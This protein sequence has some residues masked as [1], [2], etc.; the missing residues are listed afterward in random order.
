MEIKINVHIIL[1][2]RNS[3]FKYYKRMPESIYL[4]QTELNQLTSNLIA[5]DSKISSI[6][7][8][9]III[10]NYIKSFYLK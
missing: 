3:F 4:P 5:F 10:D 9:K 8:M 1:S 6:F 2:Q 7:G